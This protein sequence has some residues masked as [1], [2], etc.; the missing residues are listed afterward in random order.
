MNTASNVVITE[1]GATAYLVDYGFSRLLPP[2]QNDFPAKESPQGTPAYM[3]PEIAGS[4]VHGRPA[5]IWSIMCLLLHMLNGYAPWTRQC[6][7]VLQTYYVYPAGI[8]TSGLE[9]NP[10]N[11][12]TA[13][14]CF[15]HSVFVEDDD[16]ARCVSLPLPENTGTQ[17]WSG[18]SMVTIPEYRSLPSDQNVVDTTLSLQPTSSNS[19]SKL[20]E[21]A[22]VPPSSNDVPAN[23]AGLSVVEVPACG[24]EQAV[25]YSPSSVAVSY[26]DNDIDD[27][28]DIYSAGSDYNIPRNLP[29]RPLDE[30]EEEH[31]ALEASSDTI[32]ERGATT[33]DHATASVTAQHEAMSEQHGLVQAQGMCRR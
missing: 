22:N 14:Q 5:D 13:L 31:N 3:P 16:L 32:I 20:Q 29:L 27:D 24:S 9:K 30:V 17:S 6:E 2:G 33:G 19:A 8:H 7:T 28:E 21:S 25:E 12:P 10:E 18:P 11:R 23:P 15:Y 4:E 1:D 26:H